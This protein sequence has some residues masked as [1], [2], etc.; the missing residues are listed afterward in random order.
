MKNRG[1]SKVTLLGG[2]PGP[3]LGARSKRRS[4][5]W[6]PRSWVCHGAQPDTAKRSYVAT[7]PSRR[8]I[9]Y[10]KKHWDLVCCQKCDT[11]VRGCWCPGPEQQRVALGTWNVTSVGGKEPTLVWEVKRHQLDLVGLTS[12]HS[13]GSGTKLWER[14]WTLFFSRAAQGVRCWAGLG[15]LTSLQLSTAALEFTPVNESRLHTP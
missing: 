6:A 13:M 8:P 2:S 15:I 5:Q 9:I 1:G 3:S 14:G 11:E 4:H 12:T 7:S 10:G